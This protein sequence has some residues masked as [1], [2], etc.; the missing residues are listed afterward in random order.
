VRERALVID[1]SKVPPGVVDAIATR[2]PERA[3]DW[4]IRVEGELQELCRRYDAKPRRVLPARYGFV[5]AADT[6]NGGI[7]LRSSP[8][9]NGPM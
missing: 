7:V 2:W 1:S 3:R 9:P 4:S 8:D 5:V 6:P